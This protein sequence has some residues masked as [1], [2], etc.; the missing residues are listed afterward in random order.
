MM[1]RHAA[2]GLL[3]LVLMSAVA[4]GP[5]SSDMQDVRQ[6][7]KDIL[8]KMDDL[9]KA[10]ERVRTA[11]AGDSGQPAVDP[12]KVYSIPIDQ[13]LL[14]GPRD[15]KVTIITFSDFQCPT[16]AIAH[17]MI[18]EVLTDYPNDVNFAYKQFPLSGIHQ[19]AMQA[20]MVSLAAAKQ[21][22][23]WEMHDQLF[24]LYQH[25]SGL[26]PG[27]MMTYVKDHIAEKIGVDFAQLEK[28]MSAPEIEQAVRKDMKDGQAVGV[29]GTPTVFVG[30]KRLQKASVEGFKEMIDEAL[31]NRDGK[32]PS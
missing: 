23:F 16:S 5:S 10:V 29:V 7:Q 2:P 15:A 26:L 19:S 11:R 31:K 18:A 1:M 27:P 14:R 30:G 9:E 4:C 17:K 24:D 8:A 25:S 20:A 32:K 21:G 13:S 6:G 28:D 22:K 12:D 3:V